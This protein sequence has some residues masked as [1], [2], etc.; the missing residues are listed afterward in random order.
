M[1]WVSQPVNVSADDKPINY[2][3][4]IW[5]V[6]NVHE[7]SVKL[8]SVSSA[9]LTQSGVNVIPSGSQSAREKDLYY[10]LVG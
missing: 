8:G 6:I 7:G 2:D 9:T 5:W 10:K 3:V 1:Q 4:I